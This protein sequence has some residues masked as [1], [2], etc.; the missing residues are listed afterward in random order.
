[1]PAKRSRASMA[2][3]ADSPVEPSSKK[4]KTDAPSLSTFTKESIT[5]LTYDELRQALRTFGESPGPISDA[6]R[7]MYER[8]LLKRQQEETAAQEKAAAAPSQYASV[9]SPPTGKSSAAQ[10][11]AASSKA[12]TAAAMET[13]AQSH[14]LGSPWSS[15]SQAASSLA[16][17][18]PRTSTVSAAPTTFSSKT[19]KTSINARDT[20]GL[21]AATYTPLTSSGDINLAVIDQY[22]DHLSQQGVAGVFVN[23]TT[24][25]GVKFSVDE[26]KDL[27]ERWMSAASGKLSVFVHVGAESIKD[28]QEMAIHASEVGAH[29]IAVIAPTM[30]KPKTADHMVDYCAAVALAAPDVPLYYYHI[31]GLTGATFSI[32]DFLDSAVTRISS[33]AGV[34]YSEADLAIFNSC[35]YH[36]DRT[37]HMMYG[38]DEQLLAALA[39][40]AN[41]FVG[42]TYNLY[43]KLYHAIAK[44]FENG[45]MD[46]AR[47]LQVVSW[48]VIKILLR[49]G[50]VI[51]AGRCLL[52]HLGIAVGPPRVPDRAPD[53]AKVKL[54]IQELKATGLFQFT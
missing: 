42:S 10:R 30:F 15:S 47:D 12:S 25:E 3:V 51:P 53:A 27:V 9:L 26:R 46:E 41:T 17:P 5:K 16:S 22:A 50:G 1:M 6:T 43:P 37:L 52:E 31:T 20:R 11:S 24:G 21:V 32:E 36:N 8:M 39:M 14:L 28:A 13:Q 38:K 35:R 40:G 23:G 19:A 49:F 29:A 4:A 48:R 18:R 7:P 2:H 33:F 54:M 44:A 45:R 34:K